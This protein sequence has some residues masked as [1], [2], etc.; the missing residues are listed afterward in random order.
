VRRNLCSAR[1]SAITC[2]KVANSESE[3]CRRRGQTRQMM[4][5]QRPDSTRRRSRDMRVIIAL[6]SNPD[7]PEFA[8]PQPRPTEERKKCVPLRLTTT[9]VNFQNLNG[10]TISLSHYRGKVVLVSF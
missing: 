10:Q 2:A 3:T 8:F 5:N 9:V 1:R 7:D 6:G 4:K